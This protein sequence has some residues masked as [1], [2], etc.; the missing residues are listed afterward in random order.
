MG[1]PKYRKY[2]KTQSDSS[3]AKQEV[4]IYIKK[5]N[6]LIQDESNAKKAALIIENWLNKTPNNK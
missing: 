2:P 6:Q 4:E 5:I 1:A 3:R